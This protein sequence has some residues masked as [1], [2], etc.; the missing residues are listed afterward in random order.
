MIRDMNSLIIAAVSCVILHGNTAANLDRIEVWS[1]N[2]A[3]QGAEL[4]LFNE[5]S[6][7]G[8]WQNR[9][10]QYPQPSYRRNDYS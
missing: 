9:Q 10:G 2:A 3:A 4:V 8:Y 6:I 7:N 5:L 1:R